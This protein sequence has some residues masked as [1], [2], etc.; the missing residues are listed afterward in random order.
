MAE[1]AGMRKLFIHF[2]NFIME[3][4]VDE[5]IGKYQQDVCKKYVP[6]REIRIYWNVLLYS[7]CTLEWQQ[8]AKQL[9]FLVAALTS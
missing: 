8:H 4:G 7:T 5:T 9:W 2:E 3:N 6:L 1:H